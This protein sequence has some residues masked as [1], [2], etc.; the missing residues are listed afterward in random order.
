MSVVERSCS[1]MQMLRRQGLRSIEI[2]CRREVPDGI[3]QAHT[4]IGCEAFR[5]VP[6]IWHKE[7]ML[8]DAAE[9]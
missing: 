9:G 5:T 8:A 2:G 6:V 7:E 3:R 4:D 1:T